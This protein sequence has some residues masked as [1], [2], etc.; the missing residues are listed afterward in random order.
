[1]DAAEGRR[2]G[3]QEGRISDVYTISRRGIRGS[4]PLFSLIS[5]LFPPPYNPTEQW[6]E[7]EAKRLRREDSEDTAIA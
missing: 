6:A 2:A 5:T 4:I 3:G 7:A 1:M